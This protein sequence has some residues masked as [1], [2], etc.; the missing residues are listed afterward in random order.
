MTSP[1][2]PNATS[3]G[4]IETPSAATDSPASLTELRK[5]REAAFTSGSYLI[6]IWHVAEG[7][8]HLYRQVDGFP[9][10]DLATALDLLKADLN[11]HGLSE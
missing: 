7:K 8:V 4:P 6:A 9:K 5:A 3:S 10:G 11:S 2:M 1:Q